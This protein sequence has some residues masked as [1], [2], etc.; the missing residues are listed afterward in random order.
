M[1]YGG[2]KGRVLDFCV[3]VGYKPIDAATPGVREVMYEVAAPIRFGHQPYG[4][5][6]QAWELSFLYRY[7][8]A[9]HAAKCNFFTDFFEGKGRVWGD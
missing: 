9:V 7:E 6:Y 5:Y 3:G 8:W 4:G 1:A 2:V